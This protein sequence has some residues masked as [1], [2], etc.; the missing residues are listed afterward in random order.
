MAGRPVVSRSVVAARRSSA[1]IFPL[2]RFLPERQEVRLGAAA[3]PGVP[4]LQPRPGA[5]PSLD[6]RAEDRAHQLSG[7]GAVAL[8]SRRVA[9]RSPP[10]IKTR[11]RTTSILK[12]V[13]QKK[14]RPVN[15][16][17][18][19]YSPLYYKTKVRSP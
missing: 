11:P 5:R 13:I 18:P 16:Q 6:P 4:G 12:A 1:L 9:S 15:I 17:S 7:E 10:G 8:G 19:M 3:A 2:A 14:E